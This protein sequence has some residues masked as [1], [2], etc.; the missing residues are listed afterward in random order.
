[1]QV[2][3]L[4]LAVAEASAQELRVAGEGKRIYRGRTHRKVHLGGDH[5]IFLCLELMHF[6]ASRSGRK[7]DVAVRG[8][9]SDD[10]VVVAPGKRCHD[11]ALEVRG[12]ERELRLQAS[13]TGGR[14]VIATLL[15]QRGIMHKDA[16]TRGNDDLR[17]VDQI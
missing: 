13:A 4:C 17:H 16:I 7:D 9:G 12:A 15:G 14:R 10:L 8:A 1:M 3:N 11:R 5:R 6:C 2:P